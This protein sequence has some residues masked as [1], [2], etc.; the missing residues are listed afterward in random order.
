[1]QTKICF[2]CKLEKPITEYY[3][4][5]Q[6][7]DG[8]LNK[9]KECA[10]KDVREREFLLRSDPEWRA[11]ERKRGRDKYYRLGYK[12]RK[13]TQESKD[14]I[15]KNYYERFPEKKAAASMSSNIKSPDGKEKH[16]W[17]YNEEH[18]KDIL[19]FTTKDHNKLHR[20][21]IY[22]QERKM[23]RNLDGVLLDTKEK[24]LVHWESIKDLD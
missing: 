5:S 11:K 7:G 17:S 15:M 24:H 21:M 14:I 10:K 18:Y 13:P 23:Y 22:D 19:F 9:C 1:M 8:H 20:Y 12:E 16:H 4:H 3:K 6:M 2:K